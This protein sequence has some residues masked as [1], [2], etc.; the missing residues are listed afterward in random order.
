MKR[1]KF[2][3]LQA[4][5]RVQLFFD[6]N[7]DAL[8]RDEAVRLRGTIDP[9]I[10]ELAA[11]EQEQKSSISGGVG[12][13]AYLEKLR[14]EIYENYV[15]N[16]GN[17]ARAELR[18]TP[19]FPMLV[20]PSRVP[21]S[22]FVTRV[23]TLIGGAEKHQAVLIDNGLRVDFIAELRAAVAGLMTASDTRSRLNSRRN[24]ATNGIDAA[25]KAVRGQL[26]V[27]DGRLSSMLKQNPALLADW[28]A[29]S[30]IHKRPITLLRGGDVN[31]GDDAESPSVEPP[32]AASD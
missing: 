12:H 11:L 8:G 31:L 14:V 28:K 9:L 19:E 6:A 7:A 24:A 4:G 3:T 26:G 23:N 13:T 20:M 22:E 10:E 25:D 16:I 32:P 17:A 1:K 21:D 5:R 27:L 29:S 18:D 2:E 15:N 30:K